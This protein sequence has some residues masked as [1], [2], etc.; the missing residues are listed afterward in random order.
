M[1]QHIGLGH[2]ARITSIDIWWPASDTRQHFTGVSKDQF[3][4]VKELGND[5]TKL[6]KQPVRTGA[7]SMAVGSK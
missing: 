7:S 3:I 6:D 4:L 2:G 1:E 5:Y